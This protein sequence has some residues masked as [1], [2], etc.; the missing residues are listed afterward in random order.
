MKPRDRFPGNFWTVIVME[1]LERGAYYS[2]LSV[3]ATY[4]VLNPSQGGLGF[5]KEAAGAI[6]GTI[7]PLLYFLP[8][9]A[10]AL[11]DRYGYRKFL[12]FAFSFMVIGYGLTGMVNTY[13][14]VFGTLIIMAFGAGIFKP[15]IT[16]TIARSTTEQN[17]SLGFG[18][19][20]WTVNLG[21]C[22]FPLVLV[23]YLKSFSYSYIFYMASGIAL[24][25]LLI[26]I[27]VYKEPSRP[28]S[29]KNISLILSEMV[30]VLKD[31]R[32]ILMIVLYSGFWI[33]YFQIYGTVQ[34]Y[35]KFHLDMAPVNSA[36][37]T[38]LGLFVSQPSW[39]FDVEHITAFT[40]GIIICLQLFI[41][42]LIRKTKPL[43]TMITGLGLGTLGFGIWMISSQAWVFMLG[44]FIFT[45][46]E[47]VAQPK[48]L[49]YIGQIAPPDKKALYMGY[50]FLYGVIGSGVGG[51]LGAHLYVLFVDN[52][53][54]PP[55]LWLTLCTLGVVSMV[56]L[57]AYDKWVAKPSNE[58]T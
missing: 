33:L 27:F 24:L 29:S 37:N 56:G 15:I 51:F 2:V 16:G 23:P 18:I 45:I 52:M 34:W 39:S 10:G 8:I 36:V 48:Y 50:S 25:L 42:A 58:L 32:F 28:K 20:Y 55:L 13:V 19:F 31:W 26:N 57:W 44:L 49:S 30:L 17:S 7:Q 22:L 43:P 9:L 38:F 46:G 12:L 4:L 54:R 41:S 47:M 53:K 40:A 3:L 11:A 35:L 21:A 14:I 1:F 6:S 5:S